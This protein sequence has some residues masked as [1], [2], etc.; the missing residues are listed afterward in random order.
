MEKEAYIHPRY[1]VTEEGDVYTIVN[2]QRYKMS[3]NY[4]KA[5]PSVNITLNNKRKGYVVHR[6]VAIAFIP[7][8][9][10]K[11]CVNHIDG[12]KLNCHVS[13]LEWVTYKENSEH[14]KRTGLHKPHWG[15]ES[16]NKHPAIKA[17]IQ[18]TKD[19]VYVAEYESQNEASR[20]T[21][22][23]TSPISSVLTNRKRTGGGFI[24][25][26]KNKADNDLYADRIK[27]SWL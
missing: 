7:N 20:I 2:G 5:Y 25:R 27:K 9:E 11:P 24:W 8:P 16:G 13:N 21:G 19:G 1:T 15:K 18:Y 3:V 6:I 12:N 14:A 17:I 26:F 4:K 23:G 10:N 22:V